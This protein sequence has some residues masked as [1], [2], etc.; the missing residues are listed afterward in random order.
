MGIEKKMATGPSTHPCCPTP[1]SHPRFICRKTPGLA[2][3]LI[4]LRWDSF[5][6]WVSEFLLS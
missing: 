4:G 3:S 5:F 1:D 6:R 2:T